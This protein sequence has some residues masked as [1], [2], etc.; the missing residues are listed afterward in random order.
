MSKLNYYFE[1]E[2]KIKATA[3]YLC[4]KDPSIKFE[5]KIAELKNQYENEDGAHHKEEMTINGQA[6]PI[7]K[8]LEM[9][10]HEP[11]EHFMVFAIC[12]GQSRLIHH[13]S[14]NDQFS[15]G[16]IDMANIDVPLVNMSLFARAVGIYVV[17]N[18]PYIYKASPSPADLLTLEAIVD[19]ADI[20][21][22]EAKAI[23]KNCTVFL[24]DF[25]IVTEFDYWSCMQ[26]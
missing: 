24:I 8:W 5:D 2:E 3:R 22:R 10:R 11:V 6:I 7:D 4:E 12:N 25:A 16:N 15:I 14:E 20:I 1:N 13:Q 18:H 19:E 17:H 9:I 21:T 23:G 26:S